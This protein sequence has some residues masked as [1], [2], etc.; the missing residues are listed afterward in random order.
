MRWTDEQMDRTIGTLLRV[1]VIAAVSVV[2]TGFV[3]HVVRSGGVHPNYGVFHGESRELTT[4]GAIVRG[5]M[6]G[7]ARGWMQL[8][9]LLLIATPV[10]RVLF[11]AF[12]FAAQ[13]DWT[14]VGITIVVLLILAYGLSGG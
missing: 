12:A 7:N 8:G 5:A 2:F 3:A 6:S 1:G 4:F 13:R 14:F 9:V 10:A 11:C